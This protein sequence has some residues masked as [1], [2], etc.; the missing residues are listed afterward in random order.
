MSG[1]QVPFSSSPT[2]STPDRRPANRKDQ[3]SFGMSGPSTT[4]AGPPPSSAGSFTPAGPPPSS[5]YGSSVLGAAEPVRPLSFSTQSYGSSPLKFDSPKAP[6]A[7]SFM[8]P[9]PTAQRSNLSFEYQASPQ[10]G[11]KDPA[12]DSEDD[13]EDYPD[14]D[15]YEDD[16]RNDYYTDEEREGDDVMSDEEAQSEE[17][18]DMDDRETPRSKPARRRRDSSN[19]QSTS[20]AALRQSTEGLDLRGSLSNSVLDKKP[21]KFSRVAK[22]IYDNLG[23][24]MVGESDD[25][26]ITTESI[27][28]KLYVEDTNEENNQE[29][30]DLALTNVPTE[31]VKI[32]ELYDKNTA[33]YDSEEYVTRI[34]PGPKAVPFTKANFIAGLALKI[35]HSLEAD[36]RGFASSTKPLPQTL[37]EWIDEYHN[38]YPSQLQEI[39]S[40]RP[41]PAHHGLFWDTILNG[42]LRGKVV[43]VIQLLREAGWKN[44]RIGA[45]DIQEKPGQTGFTGLALSHVERVIG[46]AC[47]VL[48]QC[49]AVHGDWDIQGSDWTLFRLRVS[50]AIEELKRFAEGRDGGRQQIT[51]GEDFE[52]GMSAAGR[53]GTFSKTAKKAESRVPWVIYQNLL[54]IYGLISGDLSPIVE[55]AQDW[56]EATIGLVV[57]WDE[58]KNDRRLALGRSQAAYRASARDP[59][60]KTYLRKLRRSFEIAT[61]DATDFQVNTMSSLEVALASVFEGDNEAVVGFLRTWSG[62]VSSAVAEIASL[63]GWLP[64][65][66]PRNLISMDS[67]DQDDLDL[68]G[69]D[70]P[71]TKSDGIKDSTLITYAKALSQRGEISTL[72]GN[73][74]PLIKEGWELAISIIGRLDSASRSEEVV[75]DFLK[76]FPLD[77]GATVDKLWRLLNDL[78]MTQHAESTAQAYA[79]SLAED[80]HKYGEALWYYSLSHKPAK[81]KDVLDLLISI[82]LIQ[83]TAY[84]PQAEMDDYLMDLVSSPRKTLMRLANLDVEAAE[85]LHRMLSGYAT[86]RRFYSLRDEEIFVAVGKPKMGTLARKREAFASLLAVITSSADNIRG[87]LYDEERGAVVSVDF[88]LALLGEALVFV[89]QPR[90]FVTASQVELLLKAIEDLQTVGSRINADCNEFFQTVLASTQGLKGSSPT[91]M[92]RKSTSNLSGSSSFSMIGSSMHAS[93]LQRSIGSSGVLVKGNIKRG[94]DWRHNVS[95]STT[96]DDVLRILRLALARDLAKAWLLEADSTL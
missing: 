64:Q 48:Q 19:L 72:S 22:D 63:A 43:A 47:D 52:F 17:D 34:G 10:R 93:Q 60:A 83:S 71:E 58:A 86:L 89:N 25:L 80:S 38:P 30:L 31:L 3:F 67:L 66:E 29:A 77:A 39:Q 88:L 94:W 27:V 40:H 15:E 8:R 56:C 91:D 46:Q 50:Q 61:S 13:E 6:A 49:P 4:P 36:Q 9:R 65:A 16:S 21:F 35:H 85:L 79:D 84:P 18:E 14:D 45:D 53:S 2:P 1:F 70:A 7:G 73:G 95:A 12:Y 59:E 74:M 82:S 41:S 51:A 62:P 75:G 78:G 42:L 37:L 81:V 54:T 92:L 11:S 87:G 69:I 28:T 23:T 5:F 26:V 90:S 68:L 33:S 32:W 57:W 44:A 76:S 20:Q 96:G 24:P 55:N